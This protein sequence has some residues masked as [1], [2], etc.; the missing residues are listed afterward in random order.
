MSEL[1]AAADGQAAA[2]ASENEQAS[3]D[4]IY[5]QLPDIADPYK[6]VRNND[7]TFEQFV[8]RIC[9]H[10]CPDLGKLEEHV[11]GSRGI[12]NCVTYRVC[13]ALMV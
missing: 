8:C 10:K 13:S 3:E 2:I 12:S 1:V 6:H 5:A 9:R 7:E 4:H 11:I